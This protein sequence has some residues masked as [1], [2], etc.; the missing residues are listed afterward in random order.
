MSEYKYPWPAS[1]LTPDEMRLLYLA[2]E[3][4]PNRQPITRLLAQAVRA[5]YQTQPSIPEKEK[6][7]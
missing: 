6:S 4:S 1:A 5:A 3:S 7:I 2:R